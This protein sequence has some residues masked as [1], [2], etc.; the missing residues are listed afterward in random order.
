MAGWRR[1]RRSGLDWMARWRTS[2]IRRARSTHCSLVF[3]ESIDKA[4]L[5]ITVH[6]PWVFSVRLRR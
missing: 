1:R 3:T 4:S 2:R 5:V 6:A